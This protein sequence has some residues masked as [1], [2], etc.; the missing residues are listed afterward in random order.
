MARSNVANDNV[1]LRFFESLSL[2]LLT[3]DLNAIVSVSQLNRRNSAWNNAYGK[4]FLYEAMGVTWE[5]LKQIQI[6]FGRHHLK[7]LLDFSKMTHYRRVCTCST[8]NLRCCL[9]EV[10]RSTWTS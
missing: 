1:K 2:A 4:N 8:C 10:L 6:L 3:Y 9:P 7:Y 5:S